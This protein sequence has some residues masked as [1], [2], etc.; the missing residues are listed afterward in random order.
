MKWVRCK[1]DAE[2]LQAIKEYCNSQITNNN[3]CI[4]SYKLDRVSSLD[5]MEEIHELE[6]R[7]KRFND[8]LRIIEADEFMEVLVD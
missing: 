4:E 1:N 2:K 8:I 3:Y 7:N 5:Y 6:I